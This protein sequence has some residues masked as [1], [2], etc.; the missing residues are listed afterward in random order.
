MA[1]GKTAVGVPA[2]TQTIIYKEV[3]GYTKPANG[4]VTVADGKDASAT[5]TYSKS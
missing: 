1:A 5:G 4:S 3:S 2:G